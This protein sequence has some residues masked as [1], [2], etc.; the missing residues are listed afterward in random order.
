MITPGDSPMGCHKFIEVM[1]PQ[2]KPALERNV[3]NWMT[4]QK[5]HRSSR[6]TLHEYHSQLGVI[7][8]SVKRFK[9]SGVR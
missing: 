9:M 7:D 4:S 5:L 6:K 2:P 8:A 3:V 1:L